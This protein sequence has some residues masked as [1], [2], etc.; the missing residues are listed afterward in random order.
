MLERELMR[1]LTD[2][3]LMIV[4]EHG[5]DYFITEYLGMD[6]SEYKGLLKITQLIS[7]YCTKT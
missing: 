3:E 7:A 5:K 6:E 4:F 2:A 1:D